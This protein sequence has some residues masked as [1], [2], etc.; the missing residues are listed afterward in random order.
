MKLN[1]M[2][3][4]VGISL[5]LLLTALSTCSQDQPEPSTADKRVIIFKIGQEDQSDR[6]FR[7]SG[8]AG[9]EEYA[10]RIGAD[11]TDDKFPAE[12]LVPK[13]DYPSYGVERV[14]I[15]FDLQQS[16]NMVLRLV[17]G[18]D[19]TTVLIVDGQKK[20]IVTSKMLGSSE[21]FHVGAYE[22]KLGTLKSGEHSINFTVLDDGKGN[23]AYQWDAL[24]LF[25]K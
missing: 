23:G 5:L 13:S 21:G 10:C 9:Q 22:L 11:C 12:L 20:F 3:P 8:W 18:G 25:S 4:Y 17:R 2:M 6:E 7:S 24:T 15:Y 19:E 16:Y 1:Q 14:T